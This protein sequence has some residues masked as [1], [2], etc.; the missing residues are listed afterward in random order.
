VDED[1]EIRRGKKEDWIV[2]TSARRDGYIREKKLR[3]LGELNIMGM[4]GNICRTP[5]HSKFN[6]KGNAPQEDQLLLARHRLVD[7]VVVWKPNH[8]CCP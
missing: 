4:S 6:Q 7:A 1:E 3:N 5:W 8:Q 2:K